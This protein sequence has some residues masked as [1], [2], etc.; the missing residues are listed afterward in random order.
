M[1]D[2]TTLLT[3]WS[4]G[5]SKALEEVTPLIYGE[6]KSLAR[7][8]MSRE[9]AGHTLQSTALVHEAY[10]RLVDLNRIEW[11]SRTHFYGIAALL[12][13]RVLVDHARSRGSEKRGGSVEKVGLSDNI[14]AAAE[15]EV[16]L[17]LLDQALDK[18]AQI[19]ERQAKIV[20]LRFFGGLSIDETASVLNISPATVKREWVVAKAW[21]ARE[22]GTT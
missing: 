4:R 9:R 5:D 14:H 17:V 21:L 8:Y 16:D 22:L 2:L 19:D 18:L 6:L 20:E 7:A 1:P 13:R 10:L 12:V 11:Q 3:R 15:R